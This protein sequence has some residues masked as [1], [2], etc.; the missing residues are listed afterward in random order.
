MLVPKDYQNYARVNYMML[1]GLLESELL[2]NLLL[3]F[4]TLLGL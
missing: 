1:K 4:L 2:A 3:V